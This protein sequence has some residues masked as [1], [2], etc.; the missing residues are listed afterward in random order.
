MYFMTA[1]RNRLDQLANR[2]DGLRAHVE[3]FGFP[4]SEIVVPRTTR[5]PDSLSVLKNIRCFSV[6][7]AGR[8]VGFPLVATPGLLWSDAR[9]V[10]TNFLSL[11]DTHVVIIVLLG[12]DLQ[13]VHHPERIPRQGRRPDVLCVRRQ[14]V[15]EDEIRIGV[16]FAI[17]DFALVPF[18]LFDPPSLRLSIRLPPNV[19]EGSNIELFQ[20][21]RRRR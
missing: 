5:R 13:L 14:Q 12:C 15:C 17:E 11:H 4:C 21:Q 16:E 2:A 18:E 3:A 8:I 7:F 19:P 9:C 10:V 1:V 6:P 20:T